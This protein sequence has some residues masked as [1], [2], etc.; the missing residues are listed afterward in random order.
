[1]KQKPPQLPSSQDFLVSGTEEESFAVVGVGA[2]AGGLEAFVE[3]LSA[4]PQSPGMAFVLVQHLDPTH[5]SEL[6]RLLEPA[7]RMPVWEISDG[8]GVERDCVY[9]LPPGYEVDFKS[10]RL[11]LLARSVDASRPFLPVD[12][13]FRS[14]AVGVGE[15]AVGIVL[16]GMGSDGSL[17]LGEIKSRGGLVF[18]QDEFSA[19]FKQMPLNAVRGRSVDAVMAP[20][21]IAAML[22][23]I[24]G[25]GCFRN[26]ASGQDPLADSSEPKRAYRKILAALKA[27]TGVDFTEYRDNTIRRRIAR[28]MALKK[29]TSLVEYSLMLERSPEEVSKLHRDILINV[30]SFFREP[31][32]FE[33]LKR[34]VFPEI[35]RGKSAERPLRIWVPGC[36]TGQEVYSIAMALMEHL[37]GV[38]ARPVIQIFG[39]D[40]SDFASVERA[41]AAIFSEAIV[42]EVSAERLQRF[43]CKE[44]Q[45]YRIAR[46]I[47]EM[48]IFA[49]QNVAEDPP[50]SQVDLISCR[51]LLIYLSSTLQRRVIPAFHYALN[52]DGYL[53][54]G[55]SESVGRFTD[56]FHLV[57]PKNRIYT[58]VNTV[59]RA[60]PHFTKLNPSVSSAAPTLSRQTVIGAADLQREVDRLLIHRYAPPGVLVSED[61]EVLQFR[62]RTGPY[63][64]PAPGEACFDLL[65]M[66]RESLFS[67]LRFAVEEA[68]KTGQAV[69][70]EGIRHRDG[71]RIREIHLE[72]VPV[73]AIDGKR[74]GF[75]VLFEPAGWNVAGSS[76][77]VGTE[78]A[79]FREPDL[80]EVEV[81]RRDLDQTR[82]YLQAIIE[83]KAASN[84]ELRCANEEAI[85]ANEELQ[86]L[87]EELQTSKEELQSANEELTTVNEELQNRNQELARS[88]DDLM[89]LISSVKIPIVIIGTDLRVRRF[90]PA[91]T[92][93]LGL[94]PLDIGRSLSTMRL[95]LEV[96]E[97][98]TLITD[99]IATV[100]ICEREVRDAHGQWYLLRIHPYR[101]ANHRIDGA[102]AVFMDITERRMAEMLNVAQLAEI[103]A[104]NTAKDRFLAALS[105]ELRTPLTP[106]LLAASALEIRPDLPEEIRQEV[107][108]IRRNVGLEA[109]LIDDLLDLTRV[110]QGKLAV[111]L[112]ATQVLSILEKALRVVE[113]SAKMKGVRIE[114]LSSPADRGC[115]VHVDAIRM[116]QVFWNLMSNAIKFTPQG[117]RVTVRMVYEVRGWV[118]VEVQD[119]GIG[120]EAELLPRIFNA[121]EQGPERITRKYGGL[122][123]G[124]AISK[125]ILEL[126][127]GKIYAESLGAGTGS[128]FVVEIPSSMREGAGEVGLPKP[129]EM[130][131]SQLRLLVVE[132]HVDTAKVL[133]NLLVKANYEVNL[134]GTVESAKSLALERPVDLV[135]SDLGLPDGSGL[136]LMQSLKRSYAFP[137][138]ALTGYGT[139]IDRKEILAS[140]FSE[141]LVKPVDF[142]E[143]Q[144]AISR[145]TPEA[146]R[147]RIDRAR[148]G[149]DARGSQGS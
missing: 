127:G 124:L 31:D 51:N 102:V 71:D 32:V 86:S 128:T 74:G 50:F 129:E 16:S 89:N 108:M 103:S 5:P 132:D 49:K 106:V 110:A 9:V 3:F 20:A 109:Q 139:E 40:L 114:L 8:M 136:E 94:T 118:R 97:I 23:R 138:I 79:T 54:L 34:T 68:R 14:L 21:E 12:R 141:F 77:Y 11:R 85:S 87:N 113:D 45:G 126:H 105:H 22:V 88:N 90:S 15:L 64:E 144:A 115:M 58:R 121:F 112:A 6:V 69:R 92:S 2:S 19:R 122:G 143:L 72:V 98:E 147:N 78:A 145:L 107:S 149:Q 73:R 44:D 61:L 33:A 66:A 142:L 117:G 95:P 100:T 119:T 82:E 99:V 13:L 37:D 84:E 140:G 83:Q 35:L 28:R 96:P 59:V 10:G 55:A 148:S 101:T 52:T 146:I 17:G 57:D 63:L 18:A 36:S 42:E 120:I 81:L 93:L 7:S 67:P 116:Q 131:V 46:E 62:G 30:T 76:E 1:M 47:R 43:F 24:C 65:R 39:T 125:A 38:Q 104:A 75:L 25:Q 135:I 29:A 91:A 137:G 41:R 70:K 48:C 133:R 111:R 80:A 27:G 134:A 130:E 26:G 123:L 56:M 4:L 60:Y 53:V